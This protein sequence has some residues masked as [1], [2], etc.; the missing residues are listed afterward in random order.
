MGKTCSDTGLHVVLLLCG[1]DIHKE[2]N[3]SSTAMYRAHGRMR[4]I[5]FV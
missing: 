5:F 1:H 2:Y 3:S 4:R